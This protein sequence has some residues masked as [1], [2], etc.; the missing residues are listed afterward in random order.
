MKKELT[1]EKK[2]GATFTPKELAE[3]LTREILNHIDLDNNS[4]VLDPAC[5]DGVLLETIC[6]KTNSQLLG[7]DLNHEYVKSS[8]ERLN[9]F[10]GTIE[11]KDYILDDSE[12][13]IA[14]AIIAN[15][16][17]VRT[18]ILGEDFTKILAKKYNLKGRIDLYYP[19]LI[20][21]TKSL[22]EGGILG[23]I[24]SNKFLFTKGGKSIRQFLSRN[25]DILK[26]ID[27]GDTK[28]FKNAAVLPSILIARKQKG[29]DSISDFIKIYESDE[30]A[31][32]PSNSIISTLDKP[33]GLY[34]TNEGTY[35]K[36][37]GTL[38]FNNKEDVW[39]LI[40]NKQKGWIDTI[41]NSTM[42]RIKDFAKVRV[43]VKTTADN[44]FIKSDWNGIVEE[45]L[46][47]SLISKENIVKWQNPYDS[48]LKILYTHYNE[49]KKKKAI[50]FRGHKKASSYLESHRKQLEGRKYVIEAKRNWYEIWVSQNPST[51]D[52]PK[53]VF[54]DISTHPQ[55]YLDDTG[56]IVNGNCYWITSYDTSLDTLLLIQGVCNSEV[57]QKYHDIK[58]NNRLYSGR[59]RYFSQY[60]E[61]YPI[62]SADNP[63]SI[64][65]IKA[66]KK[67]N[68][69]SSKGVDITNLETKINT[70]VR[71]AFNLQ[72]ED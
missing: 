27:L 43:G 35:L 24:T 11:T 26:I 6:K 64:K 34:N 57:I 3:Y 49:G 31:I 58:F 18:Q 14:D 62:P 65:I 32:E 36:E 8:K 21:M 37:S 51:W 7:Y 19:F 16:P 46:L 60:V 39:S 55:F 56:A 59:R 23:V 25:Y 1:L 20:E 2:T 17:Y 13:G 42:S 68:K 70:L 45:E 29:S 67:L 54:P 50:D 48:S 9:N 63:Y 52:K 69:D 22:K 61:N 53:L 47:F 4:V 71:K 28:L 72:F 12:E 38:N 44:V 15:P 66:V 40:T 33:D 5:G 30:I 10:T 41:E